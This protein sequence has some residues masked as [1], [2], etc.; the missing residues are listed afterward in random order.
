MA[1]LKLFYLLFVLI[2]ADGVATNEPVYLAK[3]REHQA[4][5]HHSIAKYEEN[6]SWAIEIYCIEL[7]SLN[8]LVTE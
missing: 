2:G 4:C 1:D 6:P 7:A 3:F 5:I 8:D